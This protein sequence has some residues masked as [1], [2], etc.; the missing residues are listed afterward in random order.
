M[1][2]FPV[3]YDF[4]ENKLRMYG[5]STSLGVSA[6]LPVK[7]LKVLDSGRVPS[8]RIERKR[9]GKLTVSLTKRMTEFPTPRQG[10]VHEASWSKTSSKVSLVD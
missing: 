2:V 5:K 6:A 9:V 8:S 7:I 10:R 1:I 4:N 3:H